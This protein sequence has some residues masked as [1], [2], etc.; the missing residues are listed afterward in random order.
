MNNK[1]SI[2]SRLDFIGID[3]ATREALR[4]LRPL[5]ASALPEILDGFYAHVMKYPQVA[6]LFPNEAVIRH[7]KEAQIEHWMTIAA[8]SFDD[9]YVQSVTRIGQ[10]HN[11]LGLEPRWYIAGCSLLMTSLLL[12]IEMKNAQGWFRWRRIAGKKVVLQNAITR[13]AMLDMDF[14]VAVYL[15]SAKQDQQ[16]AMRNLAHN[17]EAAVG[18]IINTVSSAST[19]LEA[20]VSGLTKTAEMTERL[21]AAVASASVEASA[22]VQSVA[23]ATEEMSSS[24]NEIGRQVTES[25]AIADE[26]VHQAER[27]D[28]GISELSR[29]PSVSATSSSSSPPSRSKPTFWP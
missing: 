2:Q 16:T 1:Q 13:A 9:A 26:A 7:A 25:A 15:N 4:E 3:G 20:S 11:R 8:A 19:E 6:R 24:V 23:S 22:N 28:A 27:T 17:F 21:S 10:A 18:E 12:E 5:I 29:P 14:A